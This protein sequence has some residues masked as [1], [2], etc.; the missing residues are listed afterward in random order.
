MRTYLRREDFILIGGNKM[1]NYAVFDDRGILI[2]DE[3]CD[4]NEMAKLIQYR[5]LSGSNKYRMAFRM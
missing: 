5:L 4:V 3:V 2:S 1:F